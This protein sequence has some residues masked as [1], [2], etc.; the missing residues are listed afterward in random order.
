MGLTAEDFVNKSANFSNVTFKVTDGYM[1]ITPV[2][3]EV[4]VT[5]VGNYDSKVYDGTEHVVTGYEVTAISNE[6]YKESDFSFS[7]TAEAKRTEAGTTMMGLKAEDFANKSAN[8][9]NVT[10]KITDG[11]M[12]I[13]PITGE[14]VVTIAGNNTSKVY[15]GTEHEVTGYSDGS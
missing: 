1:E 3:E 9:S 13:T 8:F 11:Y 12:E 6:L 2:T 10:F 15:D 14:V 7:G 4:V 5:I